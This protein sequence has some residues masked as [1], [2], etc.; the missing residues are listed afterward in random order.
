MWWFSGLK[1]EK[2]KKEMSRGKGEK[3]NPK[4]ASNFSVSV[5]F[6]TKMLYSL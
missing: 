1:F 3:R 5:R 4:C 2:K 6:Q